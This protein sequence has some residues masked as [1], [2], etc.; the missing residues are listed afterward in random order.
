M[1]SKPTP[2]QFLHRAVTFPGPSTR[3][4]GLEISLKAVEEQLVHTRAQYEVRLKAKLKRDA[5]FLHPDDVDMERYDFEWTVDELLP[6]VFRGGF[7][8]SLWS[9]FEACVKDM[10]EYTRRIRNIPFGL[11]DLRAGDFLNQ[12]DKFFE[13]AVGLKAFPDR[14]IRKQIEELRGFRN[15]LAHHDGNTEELP[16]SLRGKDQ[17]HYEVLGLQVYRDLHHEYAVPNAEYAR[18]SLTDVHTYLESLASR[19]YAKLHPENVQDKDV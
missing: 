11:Q 13:G 16:T 17:Y 12:M 1:P 7:V 3:L 2:D 19:L 8:I 18:R 6:K 15:A 9:V 14:H 5:K 4:A 10:A